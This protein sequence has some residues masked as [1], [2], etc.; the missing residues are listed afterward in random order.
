VR[1]TP[2]PG[3]RAARLIQR[4]AQRAGLLAVP[5]ALRCGAGLRGGRRLRGRRGRRRGGPQLRAQAL[6]AGVRPP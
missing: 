6:R 3:A 5:R 1:G 4:R 2:T